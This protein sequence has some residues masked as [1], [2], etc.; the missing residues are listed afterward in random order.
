M[1]RKSVGIIF[2]SFILCISMFINFKKKADWKE[3]KYSYLN[4][5]FMK[6]IS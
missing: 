3:D 1:I 5:C 4:D 2:S 6:E